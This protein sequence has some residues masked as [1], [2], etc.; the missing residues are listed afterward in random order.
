M[1]CHIL[2]SWNLVL[3]AHMGTSGVQLSLLH[4]PACVLPSSDL[5][6][7]LLSP[8]AP[9]PRDPVPSESLTNLSKR[10]F[11]VRYAGCDVLWVP[12]TFHSLWVHL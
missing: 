5:Q 12:L 2:L 6:L 3:R 10:D 11:S 9:R 4:I 8:L 1:L 7:P